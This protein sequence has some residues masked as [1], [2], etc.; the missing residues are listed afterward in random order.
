M[1][2]LADICAWSAALDA[3]GTVGEIQ[4]KIAHDLDNQFGVEVT[5]DRGDPSWRAFGMNTSMI[6][7]TPVTELLC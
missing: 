6:R 5:N 1:H 7:P 3:K 4:S 2:S